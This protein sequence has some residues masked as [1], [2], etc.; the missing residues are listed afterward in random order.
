MSLKSLLCR[1]ALLLTALVS[2]GK[3]VDDKD[4]IISTFSIADGF[5]IEL[6]AMEPLISD[7][8]A[9]EIDEHGDVYVVE[10]HGYPLDVAGSGVV[11]KLFD[12]N[13]DGVFDRSEVFFDSL[14]LPTGIMKW[15]QGVLVADPPDL[16][17]LEDTD[18]DGRADKKEIMLTGFALSNPQ[19]NFNTPIYGLD[20]W[21][22]LANE[23]T[24]ESEFFG[25]IFGDTGSEIHF[26]GRPDSPTL[27]KN[28]NN[29]NVRV[30]L[31]NFQLEML[32]GDSQYGHTFD[33]WGH[34]FN[35]TNWSHIYHEVINA[36]YIGRNQDLEIPSSMQYVP[37][38]GIGFELYPITQNPEHQ[39]LT[40]VG[41][42]TSSCGITWYL[43]D[44]FPEPYHEV[45]FIA[46]PTHNLVH[47][48]IM[49]DKGAT[50]G[51][52]KQFEGRE[53]LASTDGW[54]RPV[55]FYIGPDGAL[56]MLDFYRKIIEHP[57]WISEEVVNSGELYQ[58]MDQGR[59]YRITP[60]GRQKNSA[61]ERKFTMA[62]ASSE[63]L[64][65][66]LGH[67]NVWWRRNA[68]RLL[69]DRQDAVVIPEIKDFI[70]SASD[71]GVLHGLWT[72]EG[73]KHF[74][75]DLLM[76]ALTHESA[77]VRENALKIAE[78]HR[79]KF[80]GL[81]QKLIGM[82]KDPNSKVRFQLLCT[83]GYFDS[84]A[85]AQARKDLLFADLEDPW[86][87][88][89]ALSASSLDSYELLNEAIDL[90]AEKPTDG[91]KTLMGNL[92]RNI[93]K[94]DDKQ[95]VND[96]ITQVTTRKNSGDKWWRVATMEGLAKAVNSDISSN[97][98]RSNLAAL[99][100]LF[101]PQED[102]VIRANSLDL[103]H[104][105]G[106]LDGQT[107]ITERARQ[108]VVNPDLNEAFR[109]DAVRV[110]AWTDPDR[111]S[112]LFRGILYEEEDPLL[113]Q[114]ALK[115]LGQ[116][117]GLEEGQFLVE[118]W[119][120]LSPGE[121]EQAVNVFT[122]D[123]NRQ[124]LFLE[125]VGSGKIRSSALDWGKTVRFLNSRDEAVRELAREVLEGNETISDSIWQQ[126]QEVLTLE[127]DAIQGARVF[128][129]SCAICHQ[130]A[131]Q[132][133]VNFGP[134]LAAVGNRNKAGIMID[135]L[136]PNRSISDGYDLWTIE[137]SSGQIYSG[138]VVS[139]NTNTI[140]LR[141]AAGE[142]V[143]IQQ[144]E[145][146]ARTASEMSAMPEG[147]YNQISLQQM[148]DLLEYLK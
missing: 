41:A 31:N 14:T 124:I 85:S 117:T 136:K 17:Y 30:D 61:K 57:E 62:Q 19:H 145:V 39:L 32:S 13:H 37:D 143:R 52:G 59:I 55:N 147:L 18:Q 6:V 105:L 107:T 111:Y 140:T 120:D 33:Q 63:E 29:L 78:L 73:L 70:K 74:E 99:S 141:N 129:Q 76:E 45:V 4:S 10:M 126:Y 146:V 139:E 142:E 36:H 84:P 148:A 24:Y 95:Q 116:T 47:T 56:Y 112:E 21:I 82:I 106:Y 92:A 12:D 94:S 138:V 35:T 103:L 86:V 100:A 38:Y 134:D 71:L 131:G 20:N 22:Y 69:V 118:N 75:S 114:E 108:V 93:A 90:L 48:D 3:A 27:P 23:G 11:K 81:E 144:S 66:Y 79:Q 54:F 113:R 98:S 42:I 91:A 122:G 119:S 49:Y 121:R 109:A 137:D 127:G 44:L 133:G 16:F 5:Q 125:A 130:I 25:D 51:S 72:L 132:D 135:I 67:P 43:G 101:H 53:F 97:I 68:Q 64:I 7:P 96:V 88:L 50:F 8:V 40:D 128:D 102:A 115:A 77:G 80:P 46:E 58:G 9:M 104:A 1:Y 123:S 65:Q 2:C 15:K 34:H 89:A 83:L 60:T 28:A 110:L 87:Q 26:P